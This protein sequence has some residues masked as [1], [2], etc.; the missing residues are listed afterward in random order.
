Y[1]LLT[2][3]RPF[4][5]ETPSARIAALL[6]REP[7]WEALPP[8]TP[9]RLRDLLQRC[10][11]KDPRDRLRD[12]GDA[13]IEIEQLRRESTSAIFSQRI[14]DIRRTIVRRRLGWVAGVV[15]LSAAFTVA[16]ESM[17]PASVP[18]QTVRT[19]ILPPEGATFGSLA[20]SPDGKQLAF[21]ASQQGKK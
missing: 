1:E 17:R 8:S 13:R 11:Q 19:E 12:V 20:L 6:E 5:G 2:A 7:D 4:G 18:D 21:V 9:V 15:L 3:K 14:G 10:L 16:Y